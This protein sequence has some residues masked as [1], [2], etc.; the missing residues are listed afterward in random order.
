MKIIDE[1]VSCFKVKYKN[2][3]ALIFVPV[4]TILVFYGVFWLVF[5]IG[6][7]GSVGDHSFVELVISIIIKPVGEEILV[8]GVILGFFMLSIPKIIVKKIS[9]EFKDKHL[10]VL[11]PAAL[12]TSS[13][14]FSYWHGTQ[15]IS[16]FYFRIAL[17]F[18][19]G[20]LY[21][22]FD[23]NIAPPIIAHIMNNALV[24]F[25]F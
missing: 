13:I 18:V 2:P 6:K 16:S 12:I 1:F 7:I 11:M 9:P 10:K 3:F 24:H 22:A 21:L 23:K 15:N 17:G 8:R 14:V 5:G 25:F 4:F 20:G 19:F